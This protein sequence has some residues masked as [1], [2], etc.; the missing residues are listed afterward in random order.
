MLCPGATVSGSEGAETP[1]AEPVMFS[2]VIVTLAVPFAVAVTLLLDVVPVTT[3]PKSRV[4]ELRLSWLVAEG[5]GATP[6]VPHPEITI[7]IRATKGKSLRTRTS[8]WFTRRSSLAGS[9]VTLVAPRDPN[10]GMRGL[11]MTKMV[12]SAGSR[13]QITA[14]RKEPIQ[15][16]VRR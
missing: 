11:L 7:A 8:G 2:W 12:G 1:K 4:V 13:L 16:N 10:R 5:A 14:D 9:V 3:L 15:D 6:V